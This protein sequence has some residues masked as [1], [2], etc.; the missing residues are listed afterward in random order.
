MES[1]IRMAKW[2]GMR[3]IAEG[4]ETREQADYLR[5]IG[6]NIIQGYFYARPM[7]LADY[8]VVLRNGHKDKKLG[9]LNVVENFDSSAF[10]TAE[11]L[12][13][14]VFNHFSGGAFIFEY[15]RG[16]CEMLRINSEFAETVCSKL[17]DE[18]I[19]K[20]EPFSAFD[21]DTREKAIAAI[22][23]AYESGKGESFEAYSTQ[24]CPPGCGE[25]LRISIRRIA[26]AGERYLFYGYVDNITA[27]KE[28]EQKER[29]I[30]TQ[31]QLI[32]NHISGGVAASVVRDGKVTYLFANNRYY[33]LM[34]RTREEYT[35]QFTGK[36]NVI[37]PDDRARVSGIIAKACAD[38]KPYSV[39]FRIVQ[40]DG[41]VRWVFSDITIVEL[42][43]LDE[44]VHLAMIND[45]TARK[46]AEEQERE[47]G[48]QLRFLN[49]MSKGL[50]SKPDAEEAILD[51]MQM[52]M[53]YFGG[54]RVY[55]VEYKDG[56]SSNTY[57]VCREGVTPQKD[58]LQNI[59]LDS[60]PFWKTAF[61]S[62]SFISI[63]TDTLPPERRIERELLEMQGIVSLVAAPI[64]ENGVYS[65]FIGIDNPQHGQRQQQNSTLSTLGDYAS[66][67]LT[68]RDLLL[69][70]KSEGRIVKA[71]VDGVPGGFCRF[72]LTED[73]RLTEGYYSR[74]YLSMLGMSHEQID[75][76]TR[77]DILAMVHPDD[78]YYSDATELIAAEARQA[79]LLDNL[80][81]GAALYEY[82]GKTLS[83]KH[84]NRHYWEMVGRVSKDYDN[85]S[86]IDAVYP[87]DRALIAQEL[88]SAIRQDREFDANI[89]ILY[90]RDAYR[91]FHIIGNIEKK[92]GGG[93]RIY[94]AY[95]PIGG[96]E[97]AVQS[98]LRL[99]L[100]AMM[101]F[102]VDFTFVKDAQG[103]Y[104][105]VSNSVV[106][107][108]GF[109][110]QEDILG[111][112]YAELFPEALTKGYISEDEEILKSGQVLLDHEETVHSADG[113]LRFI[114]TSKYPLRDT[115]GNIIGLYGISR[116]TTAFHA[117]RF[118]L[119]A[120]LH[121]IPSGVLK[122]SADDKTEFAYV[123]RNLI[124]SLGYTEQTFRE[125][126]HNCFQEMIYAEDREYVL[127]EIE[128]Q[129]GGGGIGRFDYRIEAADG[130]QRWFHDEGVKVSDESGREWYYVTLTDITN[131]KVAESIAH[132]REEE[133]RLAVNDSGII[134]C[135]YD[136]ARRTMLMPDRAVERFGFK[137]EL[138]PFPECAIAEGEIK[139]DSVEAVAAFFDSILAG[140]PDGTL[141]YQ[142]R[143]NGAWRWLDARFFSVFSEDG[144]PESA[145]VSFRDVTE[146]LQ[147]E[148]RADTDPLTGLLNRTAF[149]GRMSSLLAHSS[150]HV[151]YGLLMFDLDHFKQINDT[152][153]HSSGDETLIHFGEVLTSC[154]RSD[155]MVCRLGGDEFF[156]CLCRFA[157]RAHIERRVKRICQQIKAA[158]TGDIQ[159]SAS[160]GIAVAPDDGTDFETLYH[161]ADSALY[162]VKER[163][164][165]SYAFYNED[166]GDKNG[167]RECISDDE[168]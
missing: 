83:V 6:C 137:K 64:R 82:D 67:L 11:S 84:I 122:Y 18:E 60:T 166:M 152:Y 20:R 7:P 115:A 39:E 113:S 49:A 136:I 129:E 23:R 131:Q 93:Y 121:S 119:D 88:E 33:E 36:F 102:S 68:R 124:E 95:T 31:L 109:N 34:G 37:H 103:R 19:L 114:S 112:T 126:F 98:M 91:P 110:C 53:E 21:G 158:F 151:L 92:P 54:D 38:L 153:G 66:V 15:Y 87:D 163:G 146:L 3:V 96:D 47:T 149:S 161:K 45:I 118:E 51:S 80:P 101:D 94:A 8:E 14:L 48:K 71:V 125:R 156:V 108:L 59:P 159:V 162:Y 77:N 141:R 27:Q 55:I 167:L 154:V 130:S 72:R 4:V 2:L 150:Q 32:M 86:F 104:V 90:G 140:K 100:D 123:N 35:A 44:P 10:W 107:F 89:R 17:T 128:R 164:K 111:K 57:E 142:H 56:F 76:I 28:A 63:N 127:G 160:I 42:P 135:R 62:A 26:E 132:R 69:R 78:V 105:S 25:Y 79:E 30:A 120:L 106:E 85:I 1:V 138:Y 134:I 41:S 65:G 40:P 52:V 74:G 13:T 143:L 9:D 24:F 116:N 22:E 81:C 46:E 99:A 145:V 147:T 155:D 148:H 29:S 61:D 117:A 139:E 43:G 168:R 16:H 144:R 157:S 12:D 70:I 75:Q 58:N 97:M 165:G 73:G 5:S 50:L 133:F